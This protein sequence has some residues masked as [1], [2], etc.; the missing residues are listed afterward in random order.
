MVTADYSSV[1]NTKW[2]DVYQEKVNVFETQIFQGLLQGWFDLVCLMVIIPVDSFACQS[3][4]I[5]GEQLRD[6]VY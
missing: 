2:Q 6:P 5:V 3:F 4:D 1:Y